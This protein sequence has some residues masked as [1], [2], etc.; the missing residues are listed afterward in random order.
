MAPVPARDPPEA[1]LK[2]LPAVHPKVSKDLK[3]PARVRPRVHLRVMPV[4]VRRV[5]EVLR[6][7]REPP[8]P[9]ALAARNTGH[10]WDRR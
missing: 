10:R 5:T 4:P 3:A 7:V 9:R 8:V 2:D 1:H 6:V